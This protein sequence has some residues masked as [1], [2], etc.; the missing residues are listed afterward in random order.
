LEAAGRLNRPRK[1]RAHLE[2]VRCVCTA[3]LHE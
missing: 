3:I 1:K 2:R